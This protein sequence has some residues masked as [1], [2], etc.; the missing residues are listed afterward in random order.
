[1]MVTLCMLARRVLVLFDSYTDL[2]KRDLV[3]LA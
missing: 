1:M 2:A 3:T